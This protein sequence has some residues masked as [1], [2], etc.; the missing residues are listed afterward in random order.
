MFLTKKQGNVKKEKTFQKHPE[1]LNQ[2]KL[3]TYVR[4]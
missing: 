4:T 2:K 3:T 1:A